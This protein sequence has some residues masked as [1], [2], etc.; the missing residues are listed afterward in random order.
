M[1]KHPKEFPIFCK[2]VQKADVKIK[3]E[4]GYNGIGLC[5]TQF[6]ASDIVKGKGKF[7]TCTGTEALYRP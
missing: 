5:H 1:T 2:T 6:I 3:A 7:H 4:L